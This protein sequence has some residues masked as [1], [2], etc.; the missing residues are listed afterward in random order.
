MA[1]ERYVNWLGEVLRACARICRGPIVLLPGA[2][3]VGLVP[4]VLEAAGLT[5]RD[6][7]TW[8]KPAVEPV[9]CTGARGIR[10]GTPR[11]IAVEEIPAGGEALGGHPCPKPP[12][13][14]RALIEAA[15]RP[16]QTVLDPFSGTGTTL[17]AAVKAGRSAIGI[18]MEERFKNRVLADASSSLREIA[19]QC[20]SRG[21]AR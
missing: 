4:H 11:T 13:L 19:Q 18:E 10:P 17:V 16:G 3:N 15:T 5:W 2:M 20:G 6:E 14:M 12:A 21:T 8:L 1:P 7:L 9:V